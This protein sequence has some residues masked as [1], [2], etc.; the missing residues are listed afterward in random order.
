MKLLK[1]NSKIKIFR[2]S[3]VQVDQYFTSNPLV[4]ET[5]GLANLFGHLRTKQQTKPST[6]YLTNPSRHLPT[7]LAGCGGLLY[8]LVGGIVILKH[9]LV[10]ISV[11]CQIKELMGCGH[12]LLEGLRPHYFV[13]ASMAFIPCCF[14]AFSVTST[15]IEVTCFSDHEERGC[16]C[17]WQINLSKKKEERKIKFSS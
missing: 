17:S 14:T 6:F 1:N 8:W 10:I 9:M 11:D 4:N 3:Q 12:L 16:S 13:Y 5:Y 2:D 15:V 7:V